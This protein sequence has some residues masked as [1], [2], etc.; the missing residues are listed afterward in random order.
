[1][2]PFLTDIRFTPI[3][4]SLAGSGSKLTLFKHVL[5]KLY[6]LG[7]VM[8]VRNYTPLARSVSHKARQ[9]LLLDDASDTHPWA[10]RHFGKIVDVCC[11]TISILNQKIG[12]RRTWDIQHDGS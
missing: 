12:L 5:D 3:V 1:L 11:R 9:I 7:A 10:K 6:R 2:R 4:K 8:Q